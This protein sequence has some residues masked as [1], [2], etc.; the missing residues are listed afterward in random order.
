VII[1]PLRRKKHLP[2]GELRNP[3]NARWR[4]VGEFVNIIVVYKYL[5]FKLDRIINDRSGPL[6]IQLHVFVI[7][8]VNLEPWHKWTWLKIVWSPKLPSSVI[9]KHCKTWWCGMAGM[10]YNWHIFFKTSVQLQYKQFGEKKMYV[11]L[12]M[13]SR[14]Y[15]FKIDRISGE[16]M[17]MSKNTV[18]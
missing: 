1:S 5:Y 7:F 2:N 14:G 4:L 16:W 15:G 9:T 11:A 6:N 8:Y 10:V 17:F 12:W 18:P 13:K 3:Y